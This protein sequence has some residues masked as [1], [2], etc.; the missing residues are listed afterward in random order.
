MHTISS[1]TTDQKMQSVE[2]YPVG[3]CGI[4][5]SL[6]VVGKV[7]LALDE[8]GEE[9]WVNKVSFYRLIQR[10][11]MSY[12]NFQGINHRHE[13]Q[14]PLT[15]FNSRIINASFQNVINQ[16]SKPERLLYTIYNVYRKLH[17]G[18]TNF[19]LFDWPEAFSALTNNPKRQETVK[20]EGSHEYVLL[21]DN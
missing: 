17:E 19:S 14:D 16:Y 9:V 7:F 1:Y 13:T 8:H 4:G 12:G 21:M 5:Q 3:C 2:M 15:N 6:A 20:K 11:S 10:V 18:N